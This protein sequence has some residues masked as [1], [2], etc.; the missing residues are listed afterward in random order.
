[1]LKNYLRVA[2]RNLKRQRAHSFIN[3]TGLSVGIAA[4]LV[5]MLFV[6]YELSYEDMHADADRTYRINS[7]YAT[8]GVLEVLAVSPTKVIGYAKRDAPEVEVATRIYGFSAGAQLI[9]KQGDRAFYETRSMVGDSSFFKVFDYEFISGNP[10]GALDRE[11][12]LVLTQTM[13]LKYF[14]RTDVAGELLNLN[15]SDYTITGVI[16]DMPQN[17]NLKFDLIYSMQTFGDWAHKENWF[18]MNYQTYVKL[19]PESQPEEF[20]AKLNQRLDEEIGEDLTADGIDMHYELQG[21]KDIHY[22]TSISNDFTDNVSKDM[23]Y[24]FV[25]I[26]V[27]ILVIACI[28]YINLSTAKSERRAKEVGLRKV[29]GAQKRQLRVQFYGETIFVTAVAIV[30]AVVLAEWFMPYFNQITGL[31]LDIQYIEDP[32]I[33][34]TLGGLL[35]FIS[36]VAGSYP[37]TFLSSFQPVKVLKSTFNGVRG[38]NAFRRVLVIIQ[39]SVSVF[40]IIGT[41]VIYLQLDYVNDKDLGYEKDQSIVVRLSD[42]SARLKFKTL[43]STFE[44]VNGVDKVG[45]ANQLMSNVISGWRAEAEGLPDDVS[46]SFTGLWASKDFPETIGLPLKYGNG[47]AD[48]TDIGPERENYYIINEAGAR[49]VG[50]EP[51]E[52]VGKEFGLNPEMIGRVVGV[53]E[54]FHFASLH[55]SIEPMSIFMGK[56]AMEYFMYVKMDMTR[57]ADAIQDVEAA[58]DEVVTERPF[59]YSFLN[60]EV[61]ALYDK[62]KKTANILVLFTTLSVAIGCLGLFG[63]AAF[64]AEKRTK[65]IGI[66]KVLGAD[67]GKI[68]SLLSKEYVRIILLSNVIAWPLG[69]LIMNNWLNTFSYRIGMSWYI[70]ILAGSIT[71]MVA[72]ITVSYQSLRAAFSNPIKALRYE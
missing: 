55:Q 35:V 27:F 43:K 30:L 2:L 7:H 50:F 5:I 56:G 54:D 64:M 68:V 40:L 69:Y 61:A 31:N 22:G 32:A 62:D 15:G 51:E 37:A 63:L 41:L 9:V 65:E 16:K 20:I 18:P 49:A 14:D 11:K 25:M 57:F 24:A 12:N 26:A 72:L 36:L 44:N 4:C 58:W 66:R 38:G 13:A 28:N 60:D 17:T 23:I 59:E 70:F 46:V 71:V 45:F 33:L 39:F 34:L 53:V 8:S 47:F 10:E 48:I 42:R 1:M 21:L 52:A 3:I 67:V 29:M 6:R 19:N